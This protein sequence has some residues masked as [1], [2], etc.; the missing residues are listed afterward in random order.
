[1][2]LLLEFQTFQSPR[3]DATGAQA[4]YE[5]AMATRGCYGPWIN[6]RV[7]SPYWWA[8]PGESS[9]APIKELTT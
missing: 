8:I 3:T 2:P 6:S 7:K 1:M 4:L 5:H 9:M